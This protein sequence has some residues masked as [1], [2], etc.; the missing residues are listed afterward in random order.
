MT[1]ASLAAARR[2]DLSRRRAACPLLSLAVPVPAM[3]RL[4]AQPRTAGR[5]VCLTTRGAACSLLGALGAAACVY[6]YVSEH[7]VRRACSV[8]ASDVR[9]TPRPCTSHAHHQ[10]R[11]ISTVVAQNDEGTCAAKEWPGARG[12]VEPRDPARVL[13]THLA[14]TVRYKHTRASTRRPWRVTRQ[15]RSRSGKLHAGRR[16]SIYVK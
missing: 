16:S 14:D 13:T 2:R 11:P 9:T 1:P 7:H 5:A 15:E 6:V 12:P 8:V 3:L 4:G 10:Q